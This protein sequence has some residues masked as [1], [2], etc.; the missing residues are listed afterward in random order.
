MIPLAIHHNYSSA[1]IRQHYGASRSGLSLLTLQKALTEGAWESS[2]PR[3]RPSRTAAAVRCALG[4]SL[5]I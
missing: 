2:P 5:Q 3:P 1:T 4:P